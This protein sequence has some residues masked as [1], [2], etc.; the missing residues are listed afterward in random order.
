MAFFHPPAWIFA[1]SE[2]IYVVKLDLN[3]KVFLRERKRHTASRVAALSPDLPTGAT[4]SSPDWGGGGR[5]CH[6]VPIQS[7]QGVPP[8]FLTGGY[9]SSSDREYSHPV[10]GR[11]G[12]TPIRKNGGTVRTGWGYPPPPVRTWR[13]TPPVGEWGYPLWSEP[14]PPDGL[15]MGSPPLPV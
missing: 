11:M 13:G 7:H 14:P 6:P 8:F 15:E 5:Y 1:T 10:P 3:K 12:G 2:K 9:P 4:P